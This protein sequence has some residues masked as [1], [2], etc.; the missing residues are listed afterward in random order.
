ML[1]L[2]IQLKSQNIEY[3]NNTISLSSNQIKNL[4]KN[5]FK[6]IYGQHIEFEKAN[7]SLIVLYRR[8][9]EFNYTINVIIEDSLYIIQL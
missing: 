7:D 4:A 1:T 5:Y 6:R 3:Y 9:I 2:S 8:D